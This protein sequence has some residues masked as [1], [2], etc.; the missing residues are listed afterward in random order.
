[1]FFHQFKTFLSIINFFFTSICNFFSSIY[2][3][4]ASCVATIEQVK[5]H[6]AYTQAFAQDIPLE[7]RQKQKFWNVDQFSVLCCFIIITGFFV[8]W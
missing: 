2:L 4:I 7:S 6:S 8:E 1:M 5:V 3:R